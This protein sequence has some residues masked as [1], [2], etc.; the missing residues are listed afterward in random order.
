MKHRTKPLLNNLQKL[1]Y[2]QCFALGLQ[3]RV[4]P[5]MKREVL[6]KKEPKITIEIKLK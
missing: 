4:R 3:N 1:S 6:I 2:Q 5:V